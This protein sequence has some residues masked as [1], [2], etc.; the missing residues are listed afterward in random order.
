MPIFD[1][2]C[3]KCDTEYLN[4]LVSA[5]AT[6]YCKCGEKLVKQICAPNVGGM[7]EVGRSK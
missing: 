6:Q 5:N 7:D 1:F 4:R 2:K 3:A